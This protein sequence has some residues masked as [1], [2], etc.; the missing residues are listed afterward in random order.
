MRF[1][2]TE[3]EAA[4][5]QLLRARQLGVAFRRQQVLGAF[6]VDFLAPKVRLVVEVD[7]A[8]HALR[9]HSDRLRDRV[10]MQA[11]YTV[12]RVT[13]HAVLSNPEHCLDLVALAI[14]E[15]GF[16]E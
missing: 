4:L 11:G 2:P 16:P 9:C 7:G 12:L 6:V 1:N 15:L 3:A 5:W 13:N 14:F 8:Y 10:L